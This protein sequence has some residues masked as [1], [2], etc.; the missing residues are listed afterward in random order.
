MIFL[1]GNFRRKPFVILCYEALFRNLKEQYRTNEI[2]LAD[3][4]R[5]YAGFRGEKDIDYNLSIYPHQDFF[6]LHDIRLQIYNSHFQID[7]LILSKR[8][9]C[10]LE[11]KN[12]QGELEYNSDLHQ[13]VQKIGDK[14]I[15]IKDPIRQAEVQKAHLKMWLKKHGIEIPIETLVVISNP[16]TIINVNPG[17]P[18]IFNKL[19]RT[20]SLHL[21]LT[22]LNELR[23]RE[24]LTNSQAI[25]VKNK[26]LN[27]NIPNHPDLIKKYNITPKHLIKGIPCPSCGFNPMERIYKKWSC[28]KCLRT[29]SNVHERKILDY[30]LLHNDTITNRQCRELLQTS[31]PRIAYIA[32]NSMN[33]KST[34][35]NKARK[36]LA[37]QVS[38]FPQNSEFP[39]KSIFSLEYSKD[40]SL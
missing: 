6:I 40:I 27:E 30:F 21:S 28:P 37:P 26:L 32:L 2:V 20:E 19:I 35:K 11:I 8:F 7:T 13:L 36:Y 16:A 31:S 18:T 15:A 9:I 3:Y 22:R 17:D 25:K 23:T 14:K 29:D 33:L 1:A 5:F 24:I 34:G 4:N 10:I 38:D 12:W 39:N